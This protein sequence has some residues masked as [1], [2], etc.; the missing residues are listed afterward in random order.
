MTTHE[1]QMLDAAADAAQ[2]ARNRAKRKKWLII[3]GSTVLSNAIVPGATL[4]KIAAC[5][6]WR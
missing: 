2:D 6:S 3:L 1:T 5:R 4:S